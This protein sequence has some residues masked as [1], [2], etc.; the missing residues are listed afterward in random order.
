MNLTDRPAHWQTCEHCGDDIYQLEGV[1]LH[2]THSGEGDPK[3][4]TDRGKRAK[5]HRPLATLG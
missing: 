5:P 1:W 3:C 4:S 2:M